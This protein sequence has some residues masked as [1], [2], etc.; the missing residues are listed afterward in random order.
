LKQYA[1]D[2]P[3]ESVPELLLSSR[4]PVSRPVREVHACTPAA[5]EIKCAP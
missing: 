3:D 4:L 2:P 5:A 1:C